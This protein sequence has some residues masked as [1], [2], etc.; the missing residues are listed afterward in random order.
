MFGQS[1]LEKLKE[2]NM[3]ERQ[4][5]NSEDDNKYIKYYVLINCFFYLCVSDIC[6]CIGRQ[7]A[8]W[9]VYYFLFLNLYRAATSI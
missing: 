3:N 5:T 4:Q 8:P 2:L 1:I 6:S 9:T 7:E